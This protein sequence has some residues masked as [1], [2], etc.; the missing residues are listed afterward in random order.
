M[1]VIDNRQTSGRTG[2]ASPLDN[3]LSSLRL[4]QDWDQD[5]QAQDMV[6]DSLGQV[7]DNNFVMVRNVKLDGLDV[8]IPL[9]LVGP[10]GL[11][12]I[13]ASALRGIYRA[14]GDVWEQMDD[15]QQVFKPVLPN[16]ISR[17]TLMSQAVEEF[18][19]E[20][21]PFMLVEPVLVFYDPGTHVDTIRPD[22]RIILADG[23]ERFCAGLLQSGSRLERNTV[24]A[25]VD[26]FSH[27]STG[28]AQEAAAI[29]ERDVFSFRDEE[30]E[31]KGPSLRDRLPSDE[32]ILSFFNNMPFTTRQWVVLLLMAGFNV[33]LILAFLM[34]VLLN[35]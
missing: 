30:M 26:M 19:K 17:V 20:D 4:S 5:V 22:V 25:L 23:L 18:L 16:M 29:S 14:K 2:P 1:K 27:T 33:V 32:P 3:V 35:Q 7:L 6:V 12:V 8:P 13:Y 34:L 10:P 24:Q 11:Y 15:Q 31:A 21:H 28:E 9:I